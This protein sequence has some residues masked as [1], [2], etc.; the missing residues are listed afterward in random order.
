[1]TTIIFDPKKK[2]QLS[3]GSLELH[4]NHAV[5]SLETFFPDKNGLFVTSL[6]EETIKKL[7]QFLVKNL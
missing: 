2:T 6:P 4:C 5:F 7:I 3:K 1:M